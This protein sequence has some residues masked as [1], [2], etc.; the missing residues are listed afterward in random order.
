MTREITQRT[1]EEAYAKAHRERAAVAA[2]AWTWLFNRSS[3]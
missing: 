3:R 1:Y 2:H